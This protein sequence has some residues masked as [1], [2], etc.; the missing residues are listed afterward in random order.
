MEAAVLH[1]VHKYAHVYIYMCSVW[2]EVISSDFRCLVCCP[3]DLLPSQWEEI[4]AYR[5]YL[6]AVSFSSI[7]CLNVPYKQFRIDN[8]GLKLGEMNH[9]QLCVHA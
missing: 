6:L 5:G 8:F 2:V 4:D 1:C 9:T 3:V 7:S